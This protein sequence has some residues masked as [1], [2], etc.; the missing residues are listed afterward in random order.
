MNSI[1]KVVL[2][3]P[4]SRGYERTLLAGIAKYAKTNGPWLFYMDLPDYLAKRSTKKK[5][6]WLNT[7][8]ADGIIARIPSI[9]TVEDLIQTKLPFIFTNIYRTLKDLPSIL[10]DCEGVAAMGA[11]YFIGKGFRSFAFCGFKD[12]YWCRKR[13]EFFGTAVHAWGYE[14]HYFF[15]KSGQLQKAWRKEESAMTEWL[16]RLPKPIGILT[17]NDDLG[18]HVIQA[19]RIAK[20]MVPEEV[21]VLGA[22]N[23]SLV[24]ELSEPSLSS[25]AYNIESSG[26]KAAEILDK[27]MKKEPVSELNVIIKPTHVATRQSTDVLAID[28]PAIAKA[29]N[30]IQQ[31]FKEPIR[32]TDVARASAVSIRILQN[33]F[34]DLLGRT[35]HEEITRVKMEHA[36]KT[37]TETNKTISNIAYSLGFEEVKYFTRLF[38][39][40]KGISPMA[41]RKKF[42]QT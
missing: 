22:D 5:L 6:D 11:E 40:A 18:R 4:S 24:C 19:C 26:Y 9:Y 39:R 2:L 30:F 35:P 34:R 25:I 13:G 20:L 42:G 16:L 15:E 38:S 3:I 10:P 29:L 31:N 14:S 1:F 36:A 33:K 17:S 8:G 27:M 7:I 21:A 12:N 41:Y 28:D 32:V 37:L 23:D